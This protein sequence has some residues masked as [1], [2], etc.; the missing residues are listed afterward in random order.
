MSGGLNHGTD[1]EEN[2][3][4]SQGPLAGDAIG[5]IWKEQAADKGAKLQHA[6]HEADIEAVS[7]AAGAGFGVCV[8]ELVHDED[9]TNHTLI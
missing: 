2:G 4:D 7:R 5:E 3:S 8:V 1:A 9:D 6:G